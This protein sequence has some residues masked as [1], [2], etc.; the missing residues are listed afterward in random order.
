[1][2]PVSTAAEWNEL[3]KLFYRKRE[4]YRMVWS[5]ISALDHELVACA[6]YGGPIA[7]VRDDKKLMRL[8][9][10]QTGKPVVRI[11]N[12]AGRSL[13]S[14]PW[15]ES[16]RLVA[17]GWT[18]E[19]VLLCVAENGAVL[20][21]SVRGEL[22]P[23][24]FSLGSEV[25]SKGI[26]ECHIWGN[27]LVVLTTSNL[28]FAVT[29]LRDP[30]VQRLADPNLSRD[31]PPTCMAVIEPQHT[32]SGAVEV[33][34]A[35]DG[36]ILTVDSERVQD[37]GV[38][39]GIVL[40]MAVAPSGQLLACFTH[41]GR[42]LVMSTNF[43]KILPEFST[44]SS[45]PPEQLVWCGVD[46]VMLYWDEIL[47]MVGPYGDW[48]KY[49]Y[50]EPAILAPECDGVRII[51]RAKH[52][53]LQR[54]PDCLV[55]IF[56]IG[57]FSPGA[58]LYDALELFDAQ[59]ARA[60]ENLRLIGS[61]LSVAVE[62]CI[63][64]AGHEFD[65]ALQRSLLRA[66]AYG[67]T[68]LG[69]FPP[70]MLAEMCKTLRVLNA[71]RAADNGIP[72]SMAQYEALTA[73][74]LVVRLVATHK[75]LLAARVSDLLGL[76]VE[77]VL[78]HWAAAKMAAS[79]KLSDKELFPMLL[80]KLQ[81][82]RGISFAQVAS[83]A[84][85]RGRPRLAAMLLDHEPRAAEQVPLLTSMGEDERALVKAIESGDTD[86]AYLAVFHLQR[87]C[88]F[89]EFVKVIREHP[90]AQDLFLA[91][92]R[93]TDPELLKSYQFSI[94]AT[95]AAA[96]AI[97]A[98]AWKFNEKKFLDGQPVGMSDVQYQARLLHQA[99][100]LYSKC[101]DCVLQ[102]AACGESGK[103]LKAQAELEVSTKQYVFIGLS[104][105]DTLYHCIVNNK[106]SIAQ[107]LRQDF[108]MSDK[109]FWWIKLKA[110]TFKKDWIVC[111]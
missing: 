50:E 9:S 39:Q 6:K 20:P 89:G 67:R 40:R 31:R 104:L 88:P 72:L 51:T 61:N 98:E 109:H 19:E 64:A 111:D 17:F 3:G 33:L 60:D 48:V 11:F 101:K 73:R 35:V 96:D 74:T 87:K 69:S 82:C 8:G 16:G 93:R 1:M 66:A 52:E 70:N 106:T 5:G 53:F 47:L 92:C 71:V 12:A 108:K 103:L 42:L 90:Q 13:V 54:V 102:K 43:S 21:Y 41:D 28:L 24:Q 91:Y 15:E 94:G 76:S 45:I 77:R 36:T 58:L 97:A 18:D 59:S 95:S 100:D 37:N 84:H 22:Q 110:L 68:F 65:I 7:L 81:T 46:S 63:E 85:R 107:D 57:S 62:E 99:E 14:F 34:L 27:G 2:G 4:L 29:N 86:L 55:S 79:T 26:K 49:T 32:M 56:G 80:D 38:A 10:T 75:H 105:H 25:A 30:R 78:L 23:N 44:K 83:S